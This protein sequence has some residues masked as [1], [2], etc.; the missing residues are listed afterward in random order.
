MTKKKITASENQHNTIVELTKKYEAAKA[1]NQ[2]LYEAL[3]AS[4]RR[5]KIL[6][7]TN[8]RLDGQR[9]VLN[10]QLTAFD[11]Q[12]KT[13][14]NRILEL[15]KYAVELQSEI[16]SLKLL[17]EKSEGNFS[18]SI[19]NH[20]TP[21]AG[22]LRLANSGVTLYR[23]E[24]GDTFF[25]VANSSPELAIAYVYSEFELY[26]LLSHEEYE[27]KATASAIIPV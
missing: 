1:E 12:K 2:K 4:E 13:L 21:L 8:E 5:I 20:Y 14:E 15:E 9:N 24:V 11:S 22:A 27:K 10:E 26:R 19:T 17:L 16:S 23:V 3:E 18:S 6:H 25:I 7:E